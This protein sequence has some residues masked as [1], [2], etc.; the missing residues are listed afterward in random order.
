MNESQDWNELS[1]RIAEWVASPE[2]QA[3]LRRTSAEIAAI[4][5][6]MER[7]RHLDPELLRKPMTI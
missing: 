7:D 6:E 1:R 3:E 2:G 5:D 4:L